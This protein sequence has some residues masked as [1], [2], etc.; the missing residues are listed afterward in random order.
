MKDFLICAISKL[1]EDSFQVLIYTRIF[2][3]IY[4]LQKQ[5]TNQQT[6]FYN[7]IIIEFSF[8]ISKPAKAAVDIGNKILL[9]LPL[10]KKL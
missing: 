10:K 1:I 8:T 3:Y 4:N 5:L 2:F 9:N 7:Q 6:F